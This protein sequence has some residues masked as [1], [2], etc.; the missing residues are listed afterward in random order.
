MTKSE[1]N[2]KEQKDFEPYSPGIEDFVRR[3][4]HEENIRT[5]REEETEKESMYLLIKPKYDL[6]KRLLNPKEA[7]IY[8]RAES[9]IREIAE[10]TPMN[11]RKEIIAMIDKRQDEYVKANQSMDP[12]DYKLPFEDLER[13]LSRKMIHDGNSSHEIFEI[14]QNIRRK[15]FCDRKEMN[16]P[17]FIPLKNGL[18]RLSTWELEDFNASRFYTWKV[19][20]TYEPEIKSLNDVPRFKKFMLESY[21]P[22]GIPLILDY[23]GY[24]MYSEFPKQKVLGLFGPEGRGKGTLIRIIK[25][26]MG[27][28]FGTISLATLFNKNANFPFQSIEGKNILSDPEMRRSFEK[29]IDF[30]KF[31][32]LFG[33]DNLPLEQKFKALVD[34]LSRAK[35]IFAANLPLFKRNNMGAFLRR[36]LIALTTAEKPDAMPGLSEMILKEEGE[37]IVSIA[38]NRLKSLIS[39]NFVFSNEKSEEEY[40]E[41]WMELANSVEV[42]LDEMM[43]PDESID[44]KIDDAYL[45]YCSWCKLK[46]IPPES[47]HQFVAKVSRVYQKK[48]VREKSDASKQE[49]F[50][51]VFKG[52]FIYSEARIMIDKKKQEE[53][54]EAIQRKNDELL[55]DDPES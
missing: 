55:S 31:N 29:D 44:T 4:L 54:E 43:F 46:G 21:E 40:A 47:K 16:P 13:E 35:G 5:I 8:E 41:L 1:N 12:K 2:G 10:K 11:M 28:G 3:I 18:L 27:Q 23:L 32:M 25:G 38:L 17:G 14:L 34:Y 9:R 50:F 52:C 37:K 30:S 51:N 45:N 33:G 22:I 24:S 19:N 49:P 6:K 39:R 36:W 20:G 15:T 42:F 53:R 48:K 26:I 7:G